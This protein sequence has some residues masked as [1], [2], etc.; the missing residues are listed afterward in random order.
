MPQMTQPQMTQM[1]QPQMTQMT[2]IQMPAA[3]AWK[4]QPDWRLLAPAFHLRAKRSGGQVG[5]R[6]VR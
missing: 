4:R 1:T 5:R 3:A 6:L 2:Q